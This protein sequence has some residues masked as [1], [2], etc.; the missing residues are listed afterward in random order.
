M[1][2]PYCPVQA[3][4]DYIPG[5]SDANLCSVHTATGGET[6]PTAIS[7]FLF[8]GGIPST[9][10]TATADLK[11]VHPANREVFHLA[12][13]TVLRQQ[14]LKLEANAHGHTSLYWFVDDQ[15]LAQA[16]TANPIFWALT[17]GAHTIH[18][19]DAQGRNDI[20]EIL[21]E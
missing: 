18:C 21:V 12:D 16:D 4:A 19:S 10:D 3:S 14:R 1:P 17:R 20:V 5:I 9:P 15:L 6:W 2:T 8:D 13:T 7:A 11:I